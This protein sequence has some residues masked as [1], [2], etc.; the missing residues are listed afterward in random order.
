VLLR[1]EHFLPDKSVLTVY[2]Q[3]TTKTYMIGSDRH[4]R[5][6]PANDVEI[7]ERFPPFAF[8]YRRSRGLP[9]NTLLVILNAEIKFRRYLRESTGSCGTPTWRYGTHGEDYTDGGTYLLGPGYSP[10]YTS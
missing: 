4:L 10:R 6:S 1:P 9:L 7:C 2:G 5:R 8:D 3:V